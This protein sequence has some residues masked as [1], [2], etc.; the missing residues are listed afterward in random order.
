LALAAPIVVS[1]RETLTTSPPVGDY[2]FFIIIVHLLDIQ[3]DT[4][5]LRGRRG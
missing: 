4:D 3:S 1:F 5:D 2:Q